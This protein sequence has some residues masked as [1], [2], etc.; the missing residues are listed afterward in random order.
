M[1]NISSSDVGYYSLAANNLMI[2]SIKEGTRTNPK[3][4]DY[5]P[6][7]ISSL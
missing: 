3:A 6:F 2:G 1:E 7:D 4:K 5:R